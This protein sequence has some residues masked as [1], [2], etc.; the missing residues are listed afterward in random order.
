MLTTVSR[1]R[2]SRVWCLPRSPFGYAA[3]EANWILV[4]R[5]SLHVLFL[6]LLERASGAD[7]ACDWALGNLFGAIKLFI[8]RGCLSCAW[9]CRGKSKLC[10]MACFHQHRVWGQVSQ[11]P[12]AVW[13]PPLSASYLL[14]SVTEG[15]SGGTWVEWGRFLVSH[16][17]VA[18]GIH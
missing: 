6:G 4:W 5:W 3:Y 15:V 1:I 12:K 8:V 18:S 2:L 7:N 16:Q 13:G 17:V 10:S 11:R 9:M 14:D